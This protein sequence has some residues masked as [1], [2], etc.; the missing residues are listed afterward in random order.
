MIFTMLLGGKAFVPAGKTSFVE[1][2]HVV[3]EINWECVL[4]NNQYVYDLE[5]KMLTSNC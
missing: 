3:L 1:K 4:D 5:R 2:I